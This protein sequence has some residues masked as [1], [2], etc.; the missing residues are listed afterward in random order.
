[1]RGFTPS[2]LKNTLNAGTYFSLL[3]YSE[4]IL[5]QT[6]LLSDSGV[7]FWASALSRTAQSIISNPLVVIKTRLEVVG[8]S[9]YNGVAHAARTIVAKEGFS[10]FFTGLKIS[11]IRDVPFSG[12]F[13]PI[14][15]FFKVYYSNL[16]G[17]E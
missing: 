16:L 8:F 4:T 12:V 5:Y 3:F 9:E 11:L 10:G 15:N 1:M 7:H 13:Y 17:T 6:G 14:Y 2:I